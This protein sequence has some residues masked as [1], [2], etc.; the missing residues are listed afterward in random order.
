VYSKL[1][2]GIGLYSQAY[3]DGQSLLQGRSAMDPLPVAG[4][5]ERGRQKSRGGYSE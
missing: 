1:T 4:A 5:A 3:A 2:I